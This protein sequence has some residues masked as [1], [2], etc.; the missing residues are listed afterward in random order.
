MERP[1]P[2]ARFWDWY[3]ALSMRRSWLLFA[4]GAALFAA[5]LPYA[6]RLYGDLR[7]DLR[8]LL[9]QGAPAAEGL[10]VLEQRIGG[11][12]HLA[13]VVRTDD[14]KAGEQFEDAL[15]KKLNELPPSLISAVHWRVDA[16]KE[17][18]DQHGALYAD[19]KDLQAARDAM[20][21]QIARANPL[22]VDIAEETDKPSKGPNFDE[23]LERIKSAYARL[24]R[25]P[26]GYLAGDNGHTLIM[27]LSPPGAAVS[28]ADDQRI[29]DSVEKAVREVDPAK[30]SKSI[31]IGY[32]GEIRGVIEAQEALVRDMEISGA[33]VLL[34]VGLALVL[35]YRTIRAVPILTM[36]LFAGVAATFALSRGVIHYLN[37]NTAF[38]GS[39]II[40]NGI[41]AGIILLAR[42]IEELRK[43]GEVQASLATALRATWLATF[44]ASAAAAVSYGSLGAVSFRGFNQFAFMGFFG[45]LI[46]WATTYF[47]MPP[48]IALQNRYWPFRDLS[49]RTHG[50]AVGW[51]AGPFANLVLRKPGLSVAIATVLAVGS[52]YGSAQFAKDPI[53]YD[54][55]KLGSRSGENRGAAYWDK[56]VDE[57]LQSYQTPTV[58]LTKTTELATAVAKSVTEAKDEKLVGTDTIDS[59]ST[60]QDF[61]P[62]D[63]PQKLELLRQIFDMLDKRPRAELPPEVRR[64]REK[65]KLEPVKLSDVPQRLTRAF[66]EK[67]GQ[68]GRIVLIYPTLATDAA[69]GRAQILHTRAVRDAA[70]KADPKALIAGQIVLTTDIVAA[71]TNDGVFTALLSFG[72]VALLTLLVM[73]S[74]KDAAWVI[75]SLSLGVLWMIGAMTVL[76]L[77]FN[78][79]NFAV[80]PITFGIGVD[81]AVN[82]YQR[83]RQTGTVE[84]ALSASGGAVALCSVS[85]ILGY[86]TLVTADNQAI[87]SFG[88]TAVIGEV[89]CLSAALF[90]LPAVLSLRDR[91]SAPAADAAHQGA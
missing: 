16:E 30:F 2:I 81:Y 13:I 44:A 79:V 40:G 57:V 27:L 4:I 43:G 66:V 73:R 67:D 65:T 87:Q 24:D 35:Y 21:A 28:L 50:R 58:V 74:A 83:Y 41:N 64:L 72:A 71:I 29:F 25:Y 9:P 52:L 75:G 80:L 34:A 33:L 1:G 15:A 38:L 22:L 91:K 53:Q 20:R 70:Y 86:A 90:A 18:L 84:E 36:P 60:L 17:F 49:E 37:P 55:R 77:K 56:R 11:L 46:C 8:E 23:A 19:V 85:T 42:Y 48:I 14:L 76:G 47:L 59:I 32:G 82:L 88:L 26:D 68:R 39:I 12:S 5:C 10:K 54:F 69:N 51:I 62:Q 31:Q 89:T 61:L 63:Q 6:V 3:A 45:M 7:T 78:F